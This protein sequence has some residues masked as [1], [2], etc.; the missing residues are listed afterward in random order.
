MSTV[1]DQVREALHGLADEARPAPLLQRLEAR[2]T[3]PA[4][5][6]RPRLTVTAVAAAVLVVALVAASLISVRADR[7]GIVEPTVDPPKVFR[8][9]DRS[10]S[11]PGRADLAV[12]L[13]PPGESRDEKPAYLKASSGAEAVVLAPADD[14]NWVWTQ[15]LSADGT[16]LV[17]QANSGAD[18]RLEIVD[19][20]TG[21]SDGLGGATGY[22][23]ALS[24][25]NAT[26]ASY[27]SRFGGQVRLHDVRAGTS[28]VLRRAELFRSE[29][30]CGGIAWSPEGDLLA[31]RDAK[32][33]VIVDRDGRVV[34]RIPGGSVTNGSMS[35]SPDGRKILFYDSPEGRFFVLQ[36]AE[37]DEV[38]LPRPPDGV[39]PIGWT[40]DRVVWL[41]GQPGAQ[42]LQTTDE[43]GADVQTWMRFAVGD[44][45]V[46]A[47][48]W[49]QDLSGGPAD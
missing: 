16:R 45:G 26:L 47:V 20:R 12:T 5:I 27:S 43:R 4:R 25:D 11:T 1:E 23:P 9:S 29:A 32:G 49:S 8:L 3:A 7:A 39:E 24:P 15:H 42:S 2:R 37:E 31:V 36:L 41:V 17:R 30:I 10:S 35:W 46:E 38:A 19:L 34:L 6:P 13:T 18:P 33:S 40:G 21:D 44:R 22:C 48:Q 14:F 28:S